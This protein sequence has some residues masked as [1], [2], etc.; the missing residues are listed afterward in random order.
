VCSGYRARGIYPDARLLIVGTSSYEGANGLALAHT[1]AN[2]VKKYLTTEQAIDPTRPDLNVSNEGI[3]KG[4]ADYL[5]P[6]NN[7]GAGTAAQY[8]AQQPAR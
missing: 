1:R 5:I 3:R 2:N 8:S 4:L 7:T 6:A